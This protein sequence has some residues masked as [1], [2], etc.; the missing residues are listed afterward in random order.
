MP[1]KNGRLHLICDKRA[2]NAQQKLLGKARLPRPHRFTRLVVPR[3]H[4]LRLILAKEAERWPWQVWG[5]RAPAVWF[6]DLDDPA[7]D[8]LDVGEGWWGPATVTG[9]TEIGVGDRARSRS[10]CAPQSEPAVHTKHA[11]MLPVANFQRSLHGG[12]NRFG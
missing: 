8:D 4:A 7:L 12:K 6:A 3:S 2:A 10:R 5:A 11:A 9:L 1:Q